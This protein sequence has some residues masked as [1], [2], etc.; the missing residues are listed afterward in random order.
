MF[1]AERAYDAY[2]SSEALLDI[3]KD[4]LCCGFRKCL[5]CA[6]RDD[7]GNEVIVIFV[8]CLDDCVE[9]LVEQ[10]GEV[11]GINNDVTPLSPTLSSFSLG[12]SARYL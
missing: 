12:A 10:F 2:D 1:S 5:P 6:G 7:E 9:V 4:V 11:L 3:G 8:Q